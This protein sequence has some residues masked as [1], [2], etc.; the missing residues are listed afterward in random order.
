MPVYINP[1]RQLRG[2]MDRL[3]NG[4]LTPT[5]EEWIPGMTRSQPA[6]N[7]CD[8]GEVLTVEME[9]P[10]VKSE[11]IDV[12]VA[13]EELTVKVE[14]PDVEQEGV[15][16]HRRERPTGSF[17]R[18]LP[19]PCAINSQKVEADLHGGV[20]TLRLPKAEKAKPRKITVA[21]T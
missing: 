7:I 20:L 18:V 16:Y 11:Q 13:G 4:F 10:G 2:E 17:T 14:R 1:F 15:T 5:F 19:L 21:G 9:V 6:V 3:L 12:S 8:Q